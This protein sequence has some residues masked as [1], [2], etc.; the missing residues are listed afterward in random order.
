MKKS[1]LKVLL[2]LVV[3]L[4]FVGTLAVSY[5]FNDSNDVFAA[6]G[7]VE[8]DPEPEFVYCAGG[9]QDD[10]EPEFVYCSGT[11][12]ELGAEFNL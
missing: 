9:V 7:G 2:F 8:N 1:T 12:F 6:A 5:T 4:M 11:G 10:P 3:A